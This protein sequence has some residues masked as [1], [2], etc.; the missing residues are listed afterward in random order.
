M[1]VTVCKEGTLLVLHRDQKDAEYP[2]T[3]RASLVPA[4]K[5]NGTVAKNRAADSSEMALTFPQLDIRS[6]VRHGQC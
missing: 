1:L 2:S 3:R 5:V 4:P 6:L